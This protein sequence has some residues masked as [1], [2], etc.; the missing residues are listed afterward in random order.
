MNRK[1]KVNQI[2]KSRAKKKSAK[3]KTSNKPKYISKA[4]REKMAL[5]AEQ[6]LDAV[7]ASVAEVEKNA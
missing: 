7:S 4:D 3:L 6:G 1:K 2:L 5:E